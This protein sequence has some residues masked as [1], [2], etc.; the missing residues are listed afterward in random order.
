[1]ICL[2]S[3]G[4]P[5]EILGGVEIKSPDEPHPSEGLP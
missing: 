2:P 4:A 1:M 3:E 5:E